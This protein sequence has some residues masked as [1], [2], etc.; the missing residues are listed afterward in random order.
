MTQQRPFP[1]PCNPANNRIRALLTL[2]HERGHDFFDFF[3]FSSLINAERTRTALQR[4][5]LWEG[6]LPSDSEFHAAV[7]PL[8]LDLPLVRYAGDIFY[9]F[10]HLDSSSHERALSTRE[11]AALST[12]EIELLVNLLPVDAA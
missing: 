11:L 4:L 9:E 1:P 8:G 10:Y 12:E 3:G 6:E 2:I 5:N 7:G